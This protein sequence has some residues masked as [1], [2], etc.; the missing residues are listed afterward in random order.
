MYVQ[1]Y[2]Q[3]LDR[4]T[5]K[6]YLNHEISEPTQDEIRLAVAYLR[7]SEDE[8]DLRKQGFITDRTWAIWSEGIL[9]QIE[10]PIYADALLR[11]RDLLPSLTKFAANGNDPLTWRVIYRW[12]SGLY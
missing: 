11:H 4:M 5:D 2:W 7:L 12:W 8:L 6:M 10:C 9:A 1:R 3:I